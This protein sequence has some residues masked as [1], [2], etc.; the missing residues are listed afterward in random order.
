LEAAYLICQE[1]PPHLKWPQY[2]KRRCPCPRPRGA[3]N[4]R[5]TTSLEGMF[6]AGDVLVSIVAF[7]EDPVVSSVGRR[8]RLRTSWKVSS[9]VVCCPVGFGT[10]VWP[11]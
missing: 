6:K 1:L 2:R 11:A 3:K 7:F 9:C 10:I 8:F 5:V 4:F